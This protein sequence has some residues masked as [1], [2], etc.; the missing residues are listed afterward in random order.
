MARKRRSSIVHQVSQAI[1]A[2]NRIGESK[3]EAKHKGVPGIHSIKQVRETLSAAQNFVKWIRENEGIKSI[4]DLTEEHYIAYLEHLTALERSAGHKQNVETALRHLQKGME[5]RSLDRGLK[6]VIF[7]PEKRI[8]NWRELKKAE[9]RSYSSEEFES[10][11]PFL[12]VNVQDSVNL[13]RY[14]GLRVRESCKIKVKHFKK[15]SGGWVLNISS[16]EATGI[17]KGG[18][19]RKTPV[20]PKFQEKLILILKDKE[21]DSTVVSVK[22]AT[23]RSAV[24]AACK[25][26]GIDQNGRG[27]H[28]FRHLYCRDRLREL[29]REKGIINK[30][31][32]MLERIMKNRDKGRKADYSILTEQDIKV[33]NLL[34]GAIDQVHEEIGHGEDRWDL[35]ERYMR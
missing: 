25:K 33:Y 30:G 2:V 28:G 16:E 11:L 18:R 12:S 4:Y 20:P 14:M 10:M 34:K 22:V 23:V 5:I 3:R 19:H 29:L 17:T 13:M 31:E 26:V 24:N 7:V 35:A 27:T 9:N 21:P 15:S 32:V 8:T 1:N 6:P